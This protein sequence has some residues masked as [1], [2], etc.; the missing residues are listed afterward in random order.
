[1]EIQEISA[2]LERNIEQHNWLEA[3]ELLEVFLGQVGY[4]RSMDV[5]LYFAYQFLPFFEHYIPQQHW[6]RIVLSHIRKNQTLDDIVF[7]EVN[8]T[9]SNYELE[10]AIENYRDGIVFLSQAYEFS[11]DDNIVYRKLSF[12]ISFLVYAIS[13]EFEAT[14]Y[15]RKWEITRNEDGVL[16]RKASVRAIEVD[17]FKASVWRNA[18][19]LLLKT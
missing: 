13:T 14:H 12:A 3:E 11:H 15:P 1:M 7:L 19:E 17:K 2:K 16:E 10:I 6:C 4:K 5:A 9:F 8:T 18:L